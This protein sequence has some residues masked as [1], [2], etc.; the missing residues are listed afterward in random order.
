MKKIKIILAS[1]TLVIVVCA[2]IFHF[3]YKNNYKTINLGNTNL[4]D[5]NIKEYIL[6]ISS[7]DAQITVTVNSNKNT[8]KY[9]MKQQYINQ[10][11]FKQEVLSPSNIQGLTIIYENGNLKIENTKLNLKQI[12]ENYTYVSENS[13]CLYTFIEDY[14][15]SSNSKFIVEDNQ[16]IMQTKI[17]NNSNKYIQ[18]KKL[19]IDKKTAKPTKLEIEDVNQKV[20]VYILYNEIKINSTNQEEILALQK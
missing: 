11:T 15:K 20:L 5:E 2:G 3:F 8:N 19:Y 1:I 9:E 14:K 17:E 13:L 16:I 7:Y 6:N 10:D 4:K 12:Y 18:N